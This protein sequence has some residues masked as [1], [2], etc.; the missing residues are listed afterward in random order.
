MEERR[1]WGEIGVWESEDDMRRVEWEEEVLRSIYKSIP[2]LCWGGSRDVDGLMGGHLLEMT[3]KVDPLEAYS[4][5][6][7]RACELDGK[8]GY[9]VREHS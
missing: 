9:E 8:D 4:S 2:R 1:E 6:L 5:Y 7:A 3:R